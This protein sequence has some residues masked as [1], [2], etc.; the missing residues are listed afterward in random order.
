M[1]EPFDELQKIVFGIQEIDETSAARLQYRLLL[2]ES[3]LRAKVSP[4]EVSIIFD[5]RQES[6]EDLADFLKQEKVKLGEV[7]EERTIDYAELVK[8][9]FEAPER[10]AVV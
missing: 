8:Q 4:S 7:V 10:K 9:G 6:R 1:E 3:V 2:K 5:P